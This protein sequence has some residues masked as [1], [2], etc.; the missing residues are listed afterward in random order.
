[1]E[2]EDLA[3]GHAHDRD[4][5]PVPRLV[6]AFLALVRADLAAPGVAR[7]RC[8]LGALD[9]VERL[10]RE[11]RR[12]AARIAVP[13]ADLLAALHL[14]GAHDDV[15]AALDVDALLL[16]GVVEILA[17]DA[18]AVLERLDA[19]EAR[20]VEQHAATDHLVL[21]LLDAALLR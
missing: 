19:L 17:G 20:D 3:H 4:R 10:E 1:L 21:G 7:Q 18:V 12:V 16:R 11:A 2:L 5:D 14:S 8:E 15:V 13:A 6:D 9:P